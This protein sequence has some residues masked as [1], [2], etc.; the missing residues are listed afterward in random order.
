MVRQIFVNLPVADLKASIAFFTRLGFA[1]NPDFTDDTATCMIVGEN[2]F[3]MLLT[4]ERFAGF[5]PHPPAD[6][7]ATTEVLLALQLESREAVDAMVKAAVSGGGNTY[8]APQDHG[9]MYQHGFQD[10]DGHV[11]EVFR[12]NT[13]QGE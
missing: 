4:R 2:I 3:A 6:A 8:S 9:F 7:R 10:L 1:F 12:M 11:W 13:P 5:A